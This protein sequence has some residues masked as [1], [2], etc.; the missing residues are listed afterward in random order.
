MPLGRSPARN[1]SDISIN[2]D[3]DMGSAYQVKALAAPASGEALRKGNK[4]IANAEIADAAAIAW[5]KVATTLAIEN[6]DI[7]TNAAIA[8]SKLALAGVAGEGHITILPIFYSAIGQGTWAFIAG[9][10]MG[11]GE[12]DNA[13][14]NANGDS[15]SYKVYL[16]AGTYTIAAVVVTATHGGKVDVSLDGN[17]IAT[18]DMYDA[19]PAG[20]KLKTDNGNVVATAGLKTLSFTLNGHTAPSEQYRCYLQVIALWRTA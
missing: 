11:G 20:D 16:D 2:S 18:F 9:T 8:A 3:L 6:A 12:F 10:C 19:S 17:V 4:D 5:T 1:S 14:S 13:D 7:A 15:V